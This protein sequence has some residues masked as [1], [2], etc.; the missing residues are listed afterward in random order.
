MKKAAA[1][2]SQVQVT[3]PS[4]PAPSSP[5]NPIFKCRW[6]GCHAYL[7]NMETLQNHIANLHGLT[8]EQL[9]EQGGYVCWWKKCSLLVQDT[10]GKWGPSEI[11]DKKED[12]MAHIKEAHLKEIAQ[13]LGDGP[14]LK[15]IGKTSRTS[16]PFDVSK[17]SF[18]SALLP[19][20]LSFASSQTCPPPKVARTD[21]YT[22]PQ[23]ILRDRA[24]YLSDSN[25]QVTTPDVSASS[26]QDDLPP[27][28]LKLLL[29]DNYIHEGQAQTAF[30]KT[31]RQDKSSPRAVAEETLKAMAARKAKI[32]AGIDRGGCILVTEEIRATLQQNPG[33]QRVVDWDY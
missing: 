1:Q 23:T 11:F 5:N 17:F 21:S 3:I 14:S 27:D 31:H 32:G 24:R 13:K 2:I 20:S 6:K 18:N 7:H 19:L 22:D 25:G 30:M 28:S 10:D 29:A 16:F 33:I 15:H 8:R 26:T 4:A 12:W 9:K